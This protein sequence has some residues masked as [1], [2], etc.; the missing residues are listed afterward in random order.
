MRIRCWRNKW[1][2]ISCLFGITAL[3]AI[4]SLIQWG[5]WPTTPT[6]ELPTAVDA[7][8]V[9]G[10]GNGQDR[11]TAACDLLVKRISPIVIVSD[12]NEQT[13][14]FLQEHGVGAAKIVQER[15]SKSTYENALHVRPLL[16]QLNARRVVIVTSWYHAKRAK[17][18][19][20]KVIPETQ[21]Y[22]T[23]QPPDLPLSHQDRQSLRRERYAIVYYA[24]RYDIWAGM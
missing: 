3:A 5:E 10:G 18:V 2:K 20:E 8:V 17:A 15:E 13:V 21:F 6:R 22:V 16:Q 7:V 9:L 14:R 11:T 12:D 1:I 4:L 24:M 19:F 23:F